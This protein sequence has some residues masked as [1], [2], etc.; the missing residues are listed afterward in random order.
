MTD[1]TLKNI[2]IELYE[3]INDVEADSNVRAEID[4]IIASNDLDNS[5]KIPQWFLD[6]W[7]SIIKRINVE[8]NYF[9]TDD[10][11]NSEGDIINFLAELADL[12]DMNYENYG[13]GITMKFR[14]LS[15]EAFICL[16][17]G[18]GVCFYEI[19]PQKE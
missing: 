19:K 15:K 18:A 17:G 11:L 8:K 2:V 12:I 6:F 13:E 9:L 1:S 16:E 5:D 7:N 10:I 14:P 4:E 3:K